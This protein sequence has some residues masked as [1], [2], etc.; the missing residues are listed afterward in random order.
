MSLWDTIR[1]GVRFNPPILPDLRSIKSAVRKVHERWPEVSIKPD[2]REREPLARQLRD[3]VAHDRWED[4]RISVVIAAAHAV[5]DQERR[6][7][8][9]LEKARSFLFAETRVSR[10]ESF[11]SGMFG[12]YLESYVAGS[13]HTQALAAALDAA[14]G[15]MNATGRR[16][17]REL[18]EILDTRKG[19]DQLALRMSRMSAPFSDLKQAGL[20]NPHGGGFMDRAHEAM[21]LQVRSELT[22][23]ERVDWYLH[24]LRPV[25]HH[26]RS[27][28]GDRAIETLVH[29]WLNQSPSDELRAHLVATLID[30]YG[31][32]RIGSNAIWNGVTSEYRK[33]IDRWLTREDMRFFISVV[34]AAQKDPMWWKRRDLWL[35]L[36]NRGYID[37]AWVA[38]S[39]EATQYAHSHLIRRDS[40]NIESR[41]G[42]QRARQNTSLLIM[43]IG[44]KVMVEGCHSYKTHVFD[45]RD[46]MAPKLF[47]EGYDCDEIM[48]RSLESKRHN[49]ISNWE[50]WVRDMINADVGRS[51][52]TIPYSKVHRPRWT[53][54]RY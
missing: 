28:G 3:R 38:F 26:V 25:G 13:A 53:G 10:S 9:D 48:Q 4:A 12:V 11:L 34:D 44:N 43:R 49:P 14:R 8:T 19:P 20:Q 17:L 1:N 46:P 39:R 50:R 40:R 29:P 5:L 6:D 33:V 30:L 45:Q 18:P 51:K 27:S 7:R 36:F 21:S 32:P 2:T 22:T 42:F 37:A 35:D 23:R 52:Y 31:D 41:F 47:E 24:W 16:I 54:R 15:R